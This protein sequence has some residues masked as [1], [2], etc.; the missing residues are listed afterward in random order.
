VSLSSYKGRTYIDI[1]QFYQ[2]KDGKTLPGRKG[3]SLKKAEWRRLK[4][5][6]ETIDQLLEN[7]D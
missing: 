7:E 3:I 5:L 2:G 4:S 6:I 1:R